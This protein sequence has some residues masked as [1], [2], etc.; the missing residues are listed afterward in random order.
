MT[1][2]DILSFEHNQEALLAGVVIGF[3]NGYLSGY[4]VLRKSALMVGS[5]SH[6]LLPGLVAASFLVGLTLLSGF[7]G[8]LLAALLVGLGAVL[9]SKRSPLDG[10]SALGIL[11]TGAFAGGLLLLQRSPERVDLDHWL[12]G[13]ILGMADSD[14]WTAFGISATVLLALTLWRRPLL[15]MLFEPNVARSVG[16][17]V[18]RLDHL[19]MAL[20]ALSLVNSLQAVG[21]ILSIGLMVTP[22]ATLHL[23]ATSPRVLFWGGGCLGAGA[24]VA[25]VFL[26]NWFDAPTGATIVVL[27]ASIFLG[28]FAF[29]Q[30]LDLRTRRN[31]STR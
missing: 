23:F 7:V 10:H 1:L 31:P 17:P 29:R 19:L 4:I 15:L 13:D 18:K 28:A 27:L 16:I 14:L 21:C 12:F 24:S 11:H 26:S 9:I 2:R 8:A 25:A 22:A 30:L 5:L 6:S 20:T 3:A